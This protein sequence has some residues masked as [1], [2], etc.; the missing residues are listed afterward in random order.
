M[1]NTLV[2]ILVLIIVA[3]AL[4]NSDDFWSVMMF[5]G[6]IV[7]AV[8]GVVCLLIY[9]A[10]IYIIHLVAMAIQLFRKAVRI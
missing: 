1:M 9:M 5:V 4:R 10:G 2:L 3:L 8:S 6:V 7:L